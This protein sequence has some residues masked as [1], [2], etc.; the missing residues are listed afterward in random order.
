MKQNKCAFCAHLFTSQVDERFQIFEFSFFPR[1][2][3]AGFYESFLSSF[4][5]NY[6]PHCIS[7][8]PQ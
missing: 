3:L 6:E 4:T 7:F 8:I 5:P 1:A 2:H